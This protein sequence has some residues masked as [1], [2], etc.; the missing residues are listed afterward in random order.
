MKTGYRTYKRVSIQTADPSKIVMMLYEGA[1]KNLHQAIE[2]FESK[3]NE[4]GSERIKKTL[5]IINYLSS[6]LDHENG[7]EISVNLDRLYDFCRNTL[8][9]ANIYAETK[10]IRDV[11]RVLQPLL[12]AWQAISSQSGDKPADVPS[13]EPDGGGA[14]KLSMVG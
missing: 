14:P 12:E 7:G 2:H 9:M 4:F 10:S 11:I 3:R 6:A 13:D 5:D 8:S 1:I